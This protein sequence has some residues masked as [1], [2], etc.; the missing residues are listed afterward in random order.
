MANKSIVVSAS[1]FAVLAAA[2]PAGAQV[3]FDNPVSLPVSYFTNYLQ[4]A[5]LDGD[6]DLDLVAPNCAGFMS[7]GPQP[8]EAYRNDGSGTFSAYAL[9]AIGN[10]PV[11]MVAIGDIEGDGDLDMFVP[12]AS[13]GAHLLFVNNGSGVF[14]DEAASRLPALV[15]RVGATEFADV[16]GDGDL[17]LFVG[18]GY[19]QG[20]SAQVLGHLLI[21]DGNGVFAAGPAMPTNTVSGADPIDVDFFDADRDFDLDILLN[22]HQGVSKLW[23]NDG[24]GNFT[25]ST[26]SLPPSQGLYHYGPSVCDV[27]GDGDLDIFTDNIGPGAGL[28]DQLAINGGNL[29]FTDESLERILSNPGADDNGIICVDAD[30][31]GDF[32]AAVVSLSDFERFLYN[33]GTGVFTHQAGKF[34]AASSDNSLWLDF[35]DLNGDGRLDA[36]TGQ[37][38]PSGPNKVYLANTTMP[39]DAVAPRIITVQTVVAQDNVAPAVRFAVSDSVVTDTGPR[40]QRANFVVGGQEIVA[41]FVGGDL[42]QAELPA[43]PEGTTVAF[44]ACATDL[45][46]N[47]GC[48]PEQSYTVGAQGTGGMGAGGNGVGGGATGG[49]G[50]GASA[51][52]GGGEEPFDIEDDDGC[53]CELPGGST[54]ERGAWALALAALALLRRRPRR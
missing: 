33:D 9:P 52:G 3:V 23:I 28:A 45:A 46:G 50:Q 30:Q 48:S 40:L 43:A 11:R 18:D 36:V 8:F 29:T 10:K 37:G 25:D 49:A 54:T 35:G 2:A 14:A 4:L 39:V 44:T 5:D 27:E 20:G 38:E 19:A 16:D 42:F 24:A 1:V 12:D 41:T 22:M 34:P 17:D 21:N 32:D 51:Q 13:T 31:D 53:G 26:A 47:E 15:S 7:T 6:G